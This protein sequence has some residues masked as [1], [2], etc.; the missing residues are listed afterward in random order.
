MAYLDTPKIRLLPFILAATF[1]PS[2]LVIAGTVANSALPTG[3]QIVSGAGSISQTGSVLN[4]QQQTSKLITNWETFNIGAGAAVNFFQPSVDAIALNRVLSADPSQI[5]GRLQANGQVVLINPMGVVF[6]A[7]SR[8]DVGGLVA[9]AMQMTDSDFLSSKLRFTQPNAA[10]KVENFGTL[11][12]REG[13]Y[14]A[15]LGAQVNNAGQIVTP[16]GSTVLA[17]GDQITLNMGVTGLVS[18]NVAAGTDSARV[19]NSGL[20][21]ADGG[22]V[23]LTAQS[24]SPMLASAVNQ[25]GTV[26][27]NSL[28]QRNGEIW[29]EAK[30][31]QTTISGTTQAAGANAGETGGRI[32]ATG[33]KV[34]LQSGSKLDAS[35]VA[36]GGQVLVGGGWQGKD[37]SITN[38]QTVTQEAGSTISVD[39]TGSGHGGKAVLWS[40]QATQMAG[41]ISARGAGAGK[42][43]Q[44]ETSS[45]GALGLTGEVNIGAESGKGGN[46]LLDPTDLTVTATG[47]EPNSVSNTSIQNTLNTGGTTVT[48]QATNN[49]TVNADISK[50]AGAKSTLVFD[51]LTGGSG[52]GSIVVNKQI[53]SIA[54]ALDI[55]FGASSSDS[56]GTVTLNNTLATNGGDV[57]FFKATTLA[58]TTPISTKI[59]ESS[60]AQSGDVIFWQ[61]VKL[62]APEYSVTINTQGPQ[63][64]GNFTGRGGNIEFKGNITSAAPSAT[65]PE[66]PQALILNTTG[67]DTGTPSIGPGT[68]TLGSSAANYI[69]GTGTQ[70]LRSLS[71]IGPQAITLNAA[72]VNLFSTSGDVITASSLLGTPQLVLNAANTVINVKGGTYGSNTG[73]ADYQQTTFDITKTAGAK[74]LTINAD[75][76]IKIKNRLI[77]GSTTS[78]TLDVA[79]NS[80]Q[81]AGAIGGAVV[82]DTAAIRSNGGNINIGSLATAA[83]GFGSDLEGITNGVYIK[84]GELTSA[85][86]DISIYGSG[87]LTTDAGAAVRI[88]G[89][90]T[91]INAQAGDLT[92]MGAQSKY[93]AAGTKDA[94]I[95]GEGGNARS[96]LQTTTGNIYITGDASGVGSDSSVTGGTR[97]DGVVVSS[98]SLIQST[99]GNITIVGKGGGGD[100]SFIDENHGIRLED[101][102]TSI[103][104]SSGNISLYGSSGGKTSATQGSNSFGLYGVGNTMYI[105]SGEGAY[106]PSTLLLTSGPTATGVITLAADSMNF[107]NTSTARLKVASAG[108]LRI[109]TE[110]ANTNIELGTAGGVAEAS[111]PAQLKLFLG[112]NWFNGGSL[113]I[114]QPGFSDV[115]IGHAAS[116]TSAS[117]INALLGST[118]SLTV[119]AAT[120]MRDHAVLEMDGVGGRVALNAALTVQGNSAGGADTARTLTINTQAGAV[121]TGTL[122]V[123][124]LQLLGS[125]DNV[126]TGPNLVSHLAANLTD[127]LIFKN[128]QALAVDTVGALDKA[129]AGSTNWL[130]GAQ[131]ATVGITTTDDTVSLLTTT[132]DLTLKQNI[133]AGT[134]SGVTSLLADQGAVTEVNTAHVSSSSLYV[135]A[136]DTSKLRND[137][138]VSTLASNVVQGSLEFRN[139]VS[140]NIGSVSALEPVVLTSGTQTNTHTGITVRDTLALYQSGGDLTQTQD[141]SADKLQLTSDAGNID[142]GRTTNDVNTIAATLTGA[143]KWLAYKDKD[144]LTVGTVSSTLGASGA[145]LTLNG[146]TTSN[147]NVTLAASSNGAAAST[148]LTV[149][150]SITAGSATVDLYS[151]QGA[152][153]ETGTAIV[154]ADKLRLNAVNTSLLNNANAVSR[155]AASI[156]GASQGLDFTNA[157]AL[158]IDSIGATYPSLGSTLNGVTLGTVA[159]RGKLFL[160]TRG[161]TSGERTITQSATAPITAGDM[162]LLSDS[163]VTLT[164]A[165]NDVAKLAANTGG[166]N[167]RYVDANNVAIGTLDRNADASATT[168]GITA[169]TTTGGATVAL[170]SVAGAITQD[171]TSPVTTQYLTLQA[172][173]GVTVDNTTNDVA[174]LAGRVSGAGQFVYSDKNAL[175]VGATTDVSG[176][177]LL[178]VQTNNGQIRLSA[179]KDA[180][181]TSGDLNLTQ[182]VIAGGASTMTLEALK[183]AI[184]ETSNVDITASYLLINAFNTTRLENTG[185][186]GKHLIGT[187][188]ANITGDAAD[189]SFRNDQALTIAS[190]T[191]QDTSVAT[192]GVATKGGSVQVATLTGDLTVT[193]NVTAGTNGSVD[194]RAGGSSDIAINGATIASTNGAASGNGTVQLVAGRNISTNTANS[195]TTALPEIRTAGDVL[196]QAVG[197]IGADGQRIE[198]QDVATLATLAGGNTWLRKLDGTDNDLTIGSVA[199]LHTGVAFGGVVA[200]RAGLVTTVGSNGAIA[201]NN[202]AGS[203]T[204][205]SDVSAN[206]TGTVDLR[207]A[208][209][210]NAIAINGATISSGSGQVQLIASGNIST[211]SANGVKNE[212]ATTGNA[213]LVSGGSIGADGYRIETSGVS[214]LAAESVGAQWLRQTLGSLTLGSVTALTPG[215][216][217]IDVAALS[218]NGLVTKSGDASI[219]LNVASG[220]LTVLKDVVANGNGS[221]DLRVKDGAVAINGATLKSGSA[222]AGNGGIQVLASGDITTTTDNGDTTEIATAGN[223]LLVSGGAVGVDGKRIETAG[224]NTLAVESAG[225]QWLRQTQG[226]LKVGAVSAL[227]SGDDALDVAA[228][229][230]DGLVTTAGNAPIALSVTSGHLTVAKDVVANGNGTVDLRAKAGKV[231]LDAASLKSGATGAGTGT[232][233]IVASDSITTTTDNGSTA[234]IA[235]AGNVLLNSGGTI[236]ADGKR[237]ELAGVSTLAA[238]SAGAQWLRQTT[239]SLTLGSVTALT[240]ADSSVDIAAVSKDGLV[241][242]ANSA[243]IALNVSAGD[244]T[245]SKNVV[246][247]GNGNIDLRAKAGNVAINGATLKSGSAGAGSGTIQVI[248]SGNISTNTA[249]GATDEIATTGNALLVAGGDIG[250]DGQRIESAGVNTLA[251]QSGGSQWLQQT[252]GALTLGAV[253]ALTPGDNTVDMTAVSKNGLVATATAQSIAVQTLN[254]GLTVNKA[255]TATGGKVTLGASAGVTQST[256]ADA[257]ITADQLRVVAGN[258]HA[259]L[260]NAANAVNTLAA[261]VTGGDVTF[262]NNQALT[263]GTVNTGTDAGQTQGVKTNTAGKAITIQTRT[264]NIALAQQVTTTADAGST[265]VVTL[266]AAGGITQTTGVLTASQAR[267]LTSAG[268]AALSN[269]ANTVGKLAAGVT[270]GGLTFVNSAA[271]SLGAVTTPTTLLSGSTTGV[272]ATAGVDVSTVSGDLSVDGALNAGGAVALNAAG[273]L[274]LNQSIVTTSTAT[275]T[276]GDS[277]TVNKDITASGAD[278]TAGTA[279]TQG[280]GNIHVGTGTLTL[281]ALDGGVNQAGTGTITA[282]RLAVDATASSSLMNAG[283]TVGVLAARTVNS[284]SAFAFTNAS[285]LVIGSVAGL[286]GITSAGTVEVQVPAH[287]ITVNKP[288]SGVGTGFNANA[289]VLRAGGRFYNNVGSAAVSASNG[290]WLIYDDNPY[291]L[292]PEMNGLAR[293]F[294]LVRTRYDDYPPTT[295]VEQGNGYITTADYIPTEDAAM[296]AKSTSG[297]SLGYGF[298]LTGSVMTTY[299]SQPNGYIA[300]GQPFTPPTTFAPV[301]LFAAGAQVPEEPLLVPVLVSVEPGQH[302]Q[303]SLS[304]VSGFGEV[305]AVTLADGQALPVW[306][307]FDKS[308]LR[309]F[310]TPPKGEPRDVALLVQVKEGEN[311]KTRRFNLKVQ[312]SKAE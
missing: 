275:L 223:V 91:N 122:T 108:E 24:A 3:G 132:G 68:I 89:A 239:G 256:S 289:V 245:V 74:T 271:L 268:G 211:N 190:V 269:S 234:E 201:L 157:I 113:G 241:T 162:L 244:L 119:A 151:G 93:A 41:A 138:V 267:L 258:G 231:I 226:A 243:A 179:S 95:I 147:G 102:A 127:D 154:S 167:L 266:S 188:A 78:G 67:A 111:D 42:G 189:F 172:A 117:S 304:Y 142:L 207:T 237:I 61:D 212:I 65:L 165:N 69:G 265:D 77:D 45:K 285:D 146:V 187:L 150:Q 257:A 9:G 174:V 274:V 299:P 303:T 276:A 250:A 284:G 144:D 4:I 307:N 56:G 155:L 46:W 263:I 259:S 29:I 288:V 94:V 301:Q 205:L 84:N 152:I 137:N 309:L 236:G 12:S 181:S 153:N 10:A 32:V 183:G 103:V 282:G 204:V 159:A 73:Y 221:I 198:L 185:A 311:G 312:V 100:K 227:L 106:N 80:F 163:N 196:L 281:V 170:Q 230:K 19:D 123:N 63:N 130:G 8:V 54:G 7:G 98:R 195:S 277:L 191:G 264:G 75:R 178:G 38:A 168:A 37:A 30:G 164:V 44:V 31:G 81:A 104:S 262:V 197:T 206:G 34:V 28:A 114:F 129:S 116:A 66:Y 235:T 1:S 149:A 272:T 76:S 57:N 64:G 182:D 169:G 53:S 291:L 219:A 248:A 16:K 87:P 175:E 279:L 176:A 253:T 208:G 220:D 215:D 232:I 270:G 273:A 6:G 115:V 308:T 131:A 252:T 72:T 210:G 261:A 50:T 15:L 27:A 140:L 143:G 171:A 254:G 134:T 135:G 25:T 133:S 47:T 200:S 11:V 39:A 238:E 222:G 82:L 86:G 145:T 295:V 62:A 5:L 48:L 88:V 109:H 246:A 177:T 186:S 296:M 121:G 193:K 35:G 49:I 283:N 213:L 92:I 20:I 55:N 302:F 101:T 290:R 23:M 158:N 251:A 225:A 36:G 51:T 99:S 173:T 18:V 148:D 125:G 139:T 224:V 21:I 79:L 255:V 310:G 71:L 58:H 203:L 13:G 249:N 83:T 260:E 247:N 192:D 97:Y 90:L 199:A 141:I 126:L 293:D 161:A 26:R 306:M 112:S 294:I 96:T 305:V 286:D 156:T 60:G 217:L 52:T 59:T 202:A 166:H 180:A 43:G 120:T 85:G 229:S 160:D 240:P 128:A 194:L 280:N 287:S 118:G 218:K 2:S 216:D 17:A 70:A 233:Q 278:L 124:S 242:T 184:T 105:G 300:I 22:N 209:T 107:V 292:N 33:D 297:V 298:P 214:T 14:V 228:V 110:H 136:R 40:E